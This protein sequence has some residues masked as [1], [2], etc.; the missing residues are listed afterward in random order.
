MF[1]KK[2]KTF[3]KLRTT[4][5]KSL[6]N[7]N[8]FII[9]LI[10]LMLFLGL[11][12]RPENFQ[13][14]NQNPHEKKWED[15]LKK[16]KYFITLAAIFKNENDYLEEWLDFYVKQGIEQFYMFD[17]NDNAGHDKITNKIFDK[18]KDKITHI[19]W[20][21]VK[22]EGGNTVQRKAYQYCYDRYNHE[23]Q[24]MML[25]DIDEFGYSIE[26]NKNL[27]DIVM[28]YANPNTPY[29]KVPRF[30][31][32]NSGH[33]EKPEGGV[34][35]NFTRREK[36][37]SSYKSISNVDFVDKRF[38]SMGVHR[39]LYTTDKNM[40]NKGIK[41]GCSLPESYNKI[42]LIMNHYYTKS[43]QEYVN[44]CMMWNQKPI[45]YLGKRTS[46]CYNKKEF[47]EKNINTVEDLRA[48][49]LVYNT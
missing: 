29:I 34:I 11:V 37:I 6:R 5:N 23:F 47:D 28:E 8:K 1:N 7:K 25:A 26:P 48:K 10:L 22:T 39:L 31:F 30:N 12:Y 43:Y 40:I 32:G 38:R 21:N 42:P 3:Q 36:N 33:K 17:N 49:N 46:D 16:K 18:Y 41:I 19:I 13:N 44:K 4:I 20:N 9:L 14:Q 15:S 2:I 35:K 45:N 27:R 24:W